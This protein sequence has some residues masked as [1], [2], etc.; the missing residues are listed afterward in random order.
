MSGGSVLPQLLEPIHVSSVIFGSVNEGDAV[1]AS[2]PSSYFRLKDFLPLPDY[3]SLL[4]SLNSGLSSPYMHPSV[5]QYIAVI[6]PLLLE[7]VWDKTAREEYAELI[8]NS[9]H[10]TLRAFEPFL[11]WTIFPLASGDSLIDAQ[12]IEDSITTL[13]PVEVLNDLA[14]IAEHC[15]PAPST[16]TSSQHLYLLP[17][18]VFRSI[19]LELLSDLGKVVLDE[20]EKN[21]SERITPA[22]ITVLTEEE[23]E[24]G[25]LTTVRQSLSETDV[26]TLSDDDLSSTWG[27]PDQGRSY[28]LEVDLGRITPLSRLD[29]EWEFGSSPTPIEVFISADGGKSYQA[30]ETTAISQGVGH[31]ATIFLDSKAADHIKIRHNQPLTDDDTSWTALSEIFIRF[32]QR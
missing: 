5:R 17:Q 9:G 11:G 28:E 32:R 23:D 15:L 3:K 20:L 27:V 12:T 4:L 22:G 2:A 1:L 16:E 10:D 21:S 31:T 30:I 13:L 14:T 6:S 8:R 18:S 24:S 29:I 19:R 7:R 25:R 26:A